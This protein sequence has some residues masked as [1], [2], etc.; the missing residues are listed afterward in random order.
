MAELLFF[1]FF[2]FLFCPIHFMHNSMRFTHGGTAHVYTCV[3]VCEEIHSRNFG[4]LIQRGQI[5]LSHVEFYRANNKI[6]SIVV[7]V[8]KENFHKSQNISTK[9]EE[10]RNCRNKCICDKH[11]HWM[12]CKKQPVTERISI[13]ILSGNCCEYHEPP[14]E[15]VPFAKEMLKS[16]QVHIP[17]LDWKES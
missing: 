7:A 13:V 3:S 1:H 16:S 9:L 15:H 6:W 5:G 8:L 14:N 12:T 10:H 4:I 11:W 17:D 2:F